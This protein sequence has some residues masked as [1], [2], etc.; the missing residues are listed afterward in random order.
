MGRL[1][2]RDDAGRVYVTGEVKALTR[3]DVY[4]EGHKKPLYTLVTVTIAPEPN[5]GG[6]HDAVR[7]RGPVVPE[8]R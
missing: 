7:D 1:M 6:D 3:C 4:E 2:V 8:D 5:D